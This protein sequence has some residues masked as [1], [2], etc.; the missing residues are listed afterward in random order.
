MIFT[1]DTFFLLRVADFPPRYLSKEV[2]IQTKSIDESESCW[3]L[4]LV[5]ESNYVCVN[6]K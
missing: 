1:I 2:F 4:T 5:V 3:E 6:A